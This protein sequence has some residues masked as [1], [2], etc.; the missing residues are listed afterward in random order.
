MSPR[1]A[2]GIPQD[3][4]ANLLP[5]LRPYI[6]P[7][8]VYLLAQ[9]LSTLA[10]LLELAPSLTFPIVEKILLQDI[11]I[12]A[13]SPLVSGDAFEEVLAFF[14]ALVEADRE[15]ATHVV[16]NL[17]IS[18]EKAAKTETSLTNV[19]KCIGQIV[20]SQQGIAAGTIA[21]FSKHLKVRL[22]ADEDD[23][24]SNCILNE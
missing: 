14:A 19:A 8:D 5:I 16:P 13:H 9:A 6:S 15:I 1:Y 22:G 2:N 24:H 12:I 21:E 17:V 10:L 4:P 3:L 23:F 7:S 18:V 20:K 11:Y